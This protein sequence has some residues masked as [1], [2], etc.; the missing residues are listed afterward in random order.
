M[1][2]KAEH[3]RFG[4]IICTHVS[5]W[6]S[7]HADA[8]CSANALHWWGQ[9][10]TIFT[11]CTYLAIEWGWL[12]LSQ[13]KEM[14]DKDSTRTWCPAAIKALH[15]ELMLLVVR[16]WSKS[17]FETLAYWRSLWHKNLVR[18]PCPSEILPWLFHLGHLLGQG[19]P[20][21]LE[22]CRNTSSHPRCWAETQ[23]V[24]KTL[25]TSYYAN[26]I[27][28]VIW[29]PLL[30]RILYLYSQKMGQSFSESWCEELGSINLHMALY[31]EN[32]GFWSLLEGAKH[33]SRRNASHLWRFNFLQSVSTKRILCATRSCKSYLCIL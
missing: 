8:Q 23:G 24:Q 29:D 6:Q 11:I 14:G 27:K 18:P 33:Q 2:L 19:L 3:T 15:T 17:H 25:V 7:W 10:H 30:R 26:W 28:L 21:K 12:G 31:T 20:C 9:C 5:L 1:P 22:I 16:N 13:L 32:T 4:K